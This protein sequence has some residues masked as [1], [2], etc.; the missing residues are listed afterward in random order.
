MKPLVGGREDVTA[1]PGSITDAPG[2]AAFDFLALVDDAELREEIRAVLREMQMLSDTRASAIGRSAPTSERRP[3]PPEY[4]EGMS[5]AV[6]PPE[7]RSLYDHFAWRFRDAVGRELPRKRLWFLLW[8]AEHALKT[9]VV[10]PTAAEREE[11][12]AMVLSR[13]DEK[14]LIEY[15]LDH[16]EGEHVYRVHLQLKLPQG[17]IEKVREDEGR[18]PDY[19]FRRPKW[20]EL[21]DTQKAE[22]VRLLKESGCKQTDVV[23]RLG[24]S[25][26]TVRVH[27]PKE[28]A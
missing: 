21:D 2:F 7:D 24:V 26:R 19:G 11:R 3:G 23:R 18:D 1:R 17:W 13:P 16:Y 28:A 5:A 22:Q 20:R 12:V 6:C 9:R 27:W 8:D 10:P 15:V 4:K 14:A 25:L